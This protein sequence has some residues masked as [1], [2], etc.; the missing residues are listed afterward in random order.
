LLKKNL[1]FI[2]KKITTLY[3]ILQSFQSIQWELSPIGWSGQSLSKSFIQKPTVSKPFNSK[4]VGSQKSSIFEQKSKAFLKTASLFDSLP[5]V[6]KNQRYQNPAPAFCQ[7]T[8][9]FLKGE[10]CQKAK[11]FEDLI[12]PLVF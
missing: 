12:K 6:F 2:N 3:Q 1:R 10:G 8:N 9:G 11:L 5:F 4:T 7:K